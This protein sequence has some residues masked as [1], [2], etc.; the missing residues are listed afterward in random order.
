VNISQQDKFY[1]VGVVSSS[2]NTPAAGPPIDCLFNISAFTLHIGRL[3]SIVKPEDAA[4]RVDKD[5]Y[6]K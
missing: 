4:W 1:E 3:S 5:P 2:Q 6:I